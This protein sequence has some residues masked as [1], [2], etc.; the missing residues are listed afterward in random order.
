[1]PL[2]DV[3]IS[4]VTLS[5][6]VESPAVQHGD[7]SI[8]SGISVHQTRT[9]AHTAIRAL[10][11]I[12]T[13]PSASSSSTPARRV[14]Q[15]GDPAID[16]NG[17]KYTA[18]EGRAADNHISI[19]HIRKFDPL[20]EPGI[21]LTTAQAQYL[22]VKVGDKVTIRD[23]KTGN[24]V[25]ATYFDNAGRKP[26]GMRHFEVGPALADR[27]GISYR[28]KQGKVIDAVTNLFARGRFQIEH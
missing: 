10:A 20:V 21:A 16:L 11:R 27:L 12:A 1:M 2:F 17:T 5:P 4:T 7:V 28:N 26:D 24:S 3:L 25:P 18:I 9:P 13:S 15:S 23:T 22:G 8:S 14:L 6:P 19:E